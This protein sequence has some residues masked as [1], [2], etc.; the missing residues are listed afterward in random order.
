MS[1]LR[2]LGK[3]RTHDNEKGRERRVSYRVDSTTIAPF[4]AVAI[5]DNSTPWF[6]ADFYLVGYDE[7]ESGLDC[8]IVNL[9][10]R[11]YLE[12]GSSFTFI[13]GPSNRDADASYGETNFQFVKEHFGLKF[14]TPSEITKGV[15]KFKDNTKVANEGDLIFENASEDSGTLYGSL[16]YQAAPFVTAGMES[17]FGSGSTPDVELIL[18]VISNPITMTLYEVKYYEDSDSPGTFSGYRGVLTSVPG[19]YAP[20][21]FS[22]G[23]WRTAGQSLRVFEKGGGK[24]Y[25]ATRKMMQAPFSL[26]WRTDLYG[27]AVW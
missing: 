20:A 21:G 11:D 25:L 2:M 26:D 6:D 14:A 19:T 4:R 1:V 15:K 10:G 9:V 24:V 16:D 3:V 23:E 27:S 22:S 8:W 7:I 17:T 18:L 12:S 13:I 5:G